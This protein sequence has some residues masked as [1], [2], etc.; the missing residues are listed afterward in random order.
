[1]G[2]YFWFVLQRKRQKK[3]IQSRQKVR[4]VLVDFDLDTAK[5]DK[6]S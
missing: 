4:Q 2:K 6:D 3:I 5:S 1:M